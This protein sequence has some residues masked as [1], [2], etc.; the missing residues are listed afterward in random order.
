M[1]FNK[2]KMQKISIKWEKIIFLVLNETSIIYCK[3]YYCNSEKEEEKCQGF[4]LIGCFLFEH[5]Q[6]Y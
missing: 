1:L 2:E 3:C 5:T 6:N 4:N